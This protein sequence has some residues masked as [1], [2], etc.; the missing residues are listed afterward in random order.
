MDSRPQRRRKSLAMPRIFHVRINLD[1]VSA[2][3]DTFSTDQERGEW[4]RGFLSAARG[5]QCRF[6]QGSPGWLGHAQG[7]AALSFAESF[8][9]AQAAKGKR[10]AEARK[11][12]HGSTTVQPRFNHGSTTDEPSLNLSNNRIIEQEKRDEATRA[13]APKAGI[14]TTPV[15]EIQDDPI[16]ITTTHK[17]TFGD[18]QAMHPRLHVGQGERDTWEATLATWGWDPLHEAY[19]ACVLTLRERN[20]RVLL[21]AVTKYIDEN[22][23]LKDEH[24]SHSQAS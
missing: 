12:N 1:L 4:L 9:E 17:R 19:G 16:P 10:S 2:D 24:A 18:F 20:H 5:G 22:F 14:T 23:S 6:P 13:S 7:A 8:S 11:L 3:N 21:S 15:Q